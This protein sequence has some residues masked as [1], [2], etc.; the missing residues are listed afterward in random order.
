MKSN[1]TSKRK[2][3]TAANVEARFDA[4]EDVSD[5]FD[6]KNAVRPL[7]AKERVNVDLPRWMIQRLDREA[8]RTGISRQAVIK[9]WLAE[10]LKAA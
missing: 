9:G 10:R 4:G 7:R 1:S 6:W 5:Y 2:P 8:G 3:T